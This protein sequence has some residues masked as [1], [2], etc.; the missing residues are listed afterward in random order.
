MEKS[1]AMSTM[2]S[3]LRSASASRTALLWDAVSRLSMFWW[4]QSP[5]RLSSLSGTTGSF[6]RRVSRLLRGCP[7][8]PMPRSSS[9]P[10]LGTTP[11]GIARNG[12]HGSWLNVARNPSFCI[13]AIWLAAALTPPFSE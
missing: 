5:S 4:L 1:K 13:S 6:E 7:W 2:D 12:T 9:V 8:S 3:P 11:R 10:F